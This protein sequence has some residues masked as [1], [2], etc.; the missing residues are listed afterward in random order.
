MK[1]TL[2]RLSRR[3]WYTFTS[4]IKSILLLFVESAWYCVECDRVTWGGDFV[5]DKDGVEQAYCS[6][7]ARKRKMK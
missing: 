2:K 4:P 6:R 7:C 1:L 3:V 5:K